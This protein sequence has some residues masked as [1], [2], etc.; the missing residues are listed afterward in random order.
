MTIYRFVSPCTDAT[1]PFTMV[2]FLF[3]GNLAA[4]NNP[5]TRRAGQGWT[6]NCP[7]HGNSHLRWNLGVSVRV[8]IESSPK[9]ANW[10]ASKG[11]VDEMSTGLKMP[12]VGKGKQSDPEQNPGQE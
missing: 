4:Y 6:T 1:D 12:T 9:K 7:I 8:E 5:A 10:N 3:R 11:M 2:A